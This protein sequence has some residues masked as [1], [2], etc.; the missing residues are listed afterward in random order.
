MFKRTGCTSVRV[1]LLLEKTFA[2]T[3]LKLFLLCGLGLRPEMNTE[4]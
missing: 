4:A 2:I 1:G 3:L